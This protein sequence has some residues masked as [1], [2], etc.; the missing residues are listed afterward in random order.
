[1]HLWGRNEMDD[2]KGN[3]TCDVCEEIIMKNGV[4]GT[5]EV[6]YS[7]FFGIT[8]HRCKKHHEEFMAIIENQGEKNERK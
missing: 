6:Y 3:I 5:R 1:M 4:L 2:K 7:N 8:L